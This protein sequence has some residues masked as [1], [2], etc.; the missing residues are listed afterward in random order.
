[1]AFATQA[2]TPPH[3]A[4]AL[5]L[6]ANLGNV[7]N[8]Q[9]ESGVGGAAAAKRL[10]IGNLIN[11]VLGCAAALALLNWIGPVLVAVEPDAGRAVAD[12]HTAFNI[13]L[14]VVFFPLLKPFARLLGRLL[15][16][17]VRTADPSQPIYL[18]WAARETPSIPLAGAA[19][20]ALRMVDVFE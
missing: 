13:V 6:G 2:F 17:R 1:M 7:R 12:F 8:P 3:A 9:V 5:V 4:F 19:R 10:P 20:E 18:D 16:A 15:P 14:A 11:R